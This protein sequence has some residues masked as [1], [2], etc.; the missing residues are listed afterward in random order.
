MYAYTDTGYRL[1]F[2]IRKKDEKYQFR[3]G[4]DHSKKGNDDN[5][6]NTQK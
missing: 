6:E 1:F 5:Q 3:V 4:A 2:E